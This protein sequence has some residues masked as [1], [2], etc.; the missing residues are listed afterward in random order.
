MSSCF[1]VCVL[2][3]IYLVFCIIVIPCRVGMEDMEVDKYVFECDLLY[4]HSTQQLKNCI[5]YNNVQ[6]KGLPPSWTMVFHVITFGLSH[7]SVLFCSVSPRIK[8]KN[9]L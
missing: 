4:T 6:S 2:Y 1:F 3:I 5:R 8:Q 9:K 7:L